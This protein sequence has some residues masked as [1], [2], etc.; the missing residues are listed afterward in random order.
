MKNQELIQTNLDNLKQ[1]LPQMRC[2]Q[3]GQPLA[4]QGDA[5]ITPDSSHRYPIEEGIAQLSMVGTSD[6]WGGDKGE[7]DSIPYQQR[8]EGYAKAAG[9]NKKYEK[10][11]LKR[12]S[13][14]REQRL[15]RGL[16]STLP[17]VDTLLELPC[18]GG[19]LSPAISSLAKNTLIHAD[20]ALGQVL[21]G[22]EHTPL[23][24]QQVW[25]TASAFHIPFADD[26]VDGTVCVRLSHHLPT[27]D[28]RRRLLVEL[29]RVSRQFVVM[30]YFEYHSPKNLTRRMSSKP[31]KKTMTRAEVASLAGEHGFELVKAPWLAC[32]GSGHRYAVMIRKEG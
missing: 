22:M 29:L 1:I 24:P 15:I 14:Q 31:P 9:Y 20:I 8:Y 2:P 18:G 7:A 32:I 19:R 11:F 21:Y 6:T 17:P 30:T 13:T 23:D 27:A 3:S 16:C 10:Y 26:S 4:L 25:M 12:Q 28:E 5:L